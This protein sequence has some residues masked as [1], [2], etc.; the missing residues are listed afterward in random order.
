MLHAGTDGEMRETV[1]FDK[2]QKSKVLFVEKIS[3][4][5]RIDIPSAYCTFKISEAG[6]DA[7]GVIILQYF[8]IKP[9]PTVV[10]D[11]VTLN[12]QGRIIS[13]YFSVNKGNI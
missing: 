10:L 12:I 5:C 13:F 2:K 8:H 9:T 11:N 4:Q 3:G 6:Y 7:N 1:T